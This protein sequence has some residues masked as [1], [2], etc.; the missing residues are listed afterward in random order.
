MLR[1]NIKKGDVL[2][3][4]SLILLEYR[5]EGMYLRNDNGSQFVA[6][7]VSQYP[8]DKGVYQEFSHVATPEDNA[9]I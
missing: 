7:A 9:Y 1:Y 4:L 3:I 5:F 2:V 8:K 6:Q